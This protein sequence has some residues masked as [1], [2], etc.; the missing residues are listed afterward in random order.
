MS[1]SSI[2]NVFRRLHASKQVGVIP[3]ITVGFPDI[4]TTLELIPAAV[5]AGADIIE[6]GIPFSDPLADGTTIQKASFKALLNHV[7][8]KTC[9]E[10][11]AKS[12]SSGIDTP[13]VLMGYYNQF[14]AYGV[15]EVC[16]DAALSGVNGFIV[17]DLPTEESKLLLGECEAE[18]LDLIPLLAPTSSD[19]R[20]QRACAQARGFIYCVS[21][22]GVTGRRSEISNQAEQ[23]VAKV[24]NYTDLPIA[25]G[26]GI[27]KPEHVK[28]IGRF[29]DAAIVGSALMDLLDTAPKNEKVNKIATFIRNLKNP[30]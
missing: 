9:L 5:N 6:L 26:F 20:I 12:R 25:L 30:I 28:S 22:T 4:E 7:T 3:F 1:I 24:R 19:D 17:P 18:G 10:V 27:S 14:L 13:I 11:C 2:A 8:L 16:R 23:L 29:S 21:V 15:K